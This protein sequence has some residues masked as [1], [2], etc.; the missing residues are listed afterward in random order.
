L[1]SLIAIRRGFMAFGDL[2]DQFD[3]QQAVVERGVLDQDVVGQVEMSLEVSG[4]DAAIQKLA[5]GFFGLVAFARHNVLLGRDRD[6]F[7]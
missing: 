5:L 2:P 3:L 4:R 7:G 6:F 1:L